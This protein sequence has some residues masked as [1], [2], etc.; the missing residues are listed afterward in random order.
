MLD[1]RRLRVLVAV[2]EHGGIAAAARA[3]AFTPPAVS[4][5][6]A[7][8]ERQLGLRLLDR[9]QRTARLTPDGQHLVDRARS[10]LVGLETIEADLAR[11]TA[12]DNA[13]GPR[14]VQG[15]VRVAAI[16][17]VGKALLA[18][19]LASLAAT[20]PGLDVRVEQA[21]PEASLPALQRGQV[22]VV[23]AG[24]YGLAP[25]RP[26][27]TVERLDLL[28]DPVALAVPFD[29]SITG[30][31]VT[32]ADLQDEPWVAPAAG[33]SCAV[34]LER[35]AAL[36]GYEPH[37]VARCGD[38][39]LAVALVGAG[40]GVA[41][42]PQLAATASGARSPAS[43]V[44]LLIPKDPE[45]HRTVYAA[46]RHGSRDHP[47]IACLLQAIADRARLSCVDHGPAGSSGSCCCGATS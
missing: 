38:F 32:F 19:A 43:G 47:Y 15:V 42:L 22:D 8:L 7:A 14:R 4:Q 25:R 12:G 23:L 35:S 28:R 13:A 16:A 31:S 36:A 3:L 11:L 39:A 20:A 27:S 33:T 17:T 2:A 44:R 5:Q 40:R 29:H 30:P 1:V 24:E 37:V 46:I 10:V 26:P 9:T 41:L 18:P 6:V 34:L 45:V 21:E